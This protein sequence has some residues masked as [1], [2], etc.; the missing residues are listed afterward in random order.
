MIMNVRM[1]GY[2][3]VEFLDELFNAAQARVE[4]HLV[5]FVKLVKMGGLYLLLKEIVAI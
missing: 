1:N 5:I 4:T 2:L 3:S